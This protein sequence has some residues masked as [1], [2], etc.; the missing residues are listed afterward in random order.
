MQSLP[1]QPACSHRVEH[2]AVPQMCCK[3]VS[4]GKVLQLDITSLYAYS[5]ALYGH[6]HKGTVDEGGFKRGGSTLDVDLST[7]LSLS[8]RFWDLYFFLDF[9]DLSLFCLFSL[10]WHIKRNFKISKN[11]RR[12]YRRWIHKEKLS[13]LQTHQIL[14]S[15]V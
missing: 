15:P 11:S 6:F 3:C 7:D 13:E 9:P 12:S 5:S 1:L 2:P 8:R 4:V 10:C 14:H